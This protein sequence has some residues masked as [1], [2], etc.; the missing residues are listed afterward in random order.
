MEFIYSLDDEIT[1]LVDLG[2]EYQWFLD[3][4]FPA[5]F[6]EFYDEVYKST[7]GD[8]TNFKTKITEGL[9][10]I[11]DES[12]YVLAAEQAKKSWATIENNFLQALVD[13]RLGVKPNYQ[14]YISL[15]GPSGQF[16][17]PNIINLRVV[18]DLDIKEININLAHEIVHLSIYQKVK[19]LKLNYAQTEG[20]VDLIFTETQLKNIFP[21]Y[22][23]QSGVVHDKEL[24]AKFI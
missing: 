2:E 10:K 22:Q 6:P 17:Y 11:Y 7:Y 1:R 16:F 12:K 5:I 15:Y 20:V 9:A 8:A 3:N 23:L 24:L 21:D 18:T 13:L 14:C 4:N 19:E